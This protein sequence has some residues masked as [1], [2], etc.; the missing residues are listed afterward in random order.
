MAALGDSDGQ[1]M[2]IQKYEESGYLDAMSWLADR[3]AEH[4]ASHLALQKK[5]RI[6]GELLCDPSPE[7]PGLVLAGGS[8]DP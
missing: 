1:R 8:P 7:C 6:V 4:P 3:S 5:D 2:F